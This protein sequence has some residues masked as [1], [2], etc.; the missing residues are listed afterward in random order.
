MNPTGSLFGE[1]YEKALEQNLD[2]EDNDGF[3]S[4]PTVTRIPLL[5]KDLVTASAER[6]SPSST[7]ASISIQVLPEFIEG[8]VLSNNDKTISRHICEL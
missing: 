6:C 8:G 2:E 7:I 4:A 5:P 1:G 3:F